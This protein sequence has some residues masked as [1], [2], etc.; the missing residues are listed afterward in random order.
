MIAKGNT[1]AGLG[2][3]YNLNAGSFGNFSGSTTLTGQTFAYWAY[4]NGGSYDIFPHHTRASLDGN[5]HHI[6]VSCDAT[7]VYMFVDGILST[8]SGITWTWPGAHA[9]SWSSTLTNT[10]SIGGG[11]T[12]E[13][14]LFSRAYVDDVRITHDVCRYTADFDLPAGAFQDS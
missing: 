12:Q 13:P 11:S 9:D 1:Y 5:W 3:F 14:S 8:Q 6:G 10:N 4:M 7:R 2:L